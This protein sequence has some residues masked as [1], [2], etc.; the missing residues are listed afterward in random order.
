MSTNNET[1]FENDLSDPSVSQLQGPI[2]K[3]LYAM[4]AKGVKIC[5]DLQLAPGGEIFLQDGTAGKSLV[6][7]LDLEYRF[8]EPSGAFI[9]ASLV[10]QGGD[11]YIDGD[12]N[13][14]PGAYHAGNGVV[15][16]RKAWL[17]ISRPDGSL[18]YKEADG[19]N[20]LESHIDNDGII[21]SLA[22]VVQQINQLSDMIDVALAAEEAAR[23]QDVDELEGALGEWIIDL[24]V[25]LDRMELAVRLHADM[26]DD[27]IATTMETNIAAEAFNVQAES[28]LDNFHHVLNYSTVANAVMNQLDGFELAH[29]LNQLSAY[30]VSGDLSGNTASRGDISNW[31]IRTVIKRTGSQGV[32]IRGEEVWNNAKIV[33][34]EPNGVSQLQVHIQVADCGAMTSSD[35]IIVS[36][37]FVGDRGFTLPHTD[38]YSSYRGHTYNE[39]G[40]SLVYG[41]EQYPWADSDSGAPVYKATLSPFNQ[42]PQ[43]VQVDFAGAPF[44]GATIDV[45]DGYLTEDWLPREYEITGFINGAPSGTVE[46]FLL[47]DYGD[48]W[49]G[50]TIQIFINGSLLQI[51]G[52]SSHALTGKAAMLNL[53]TLNVGDRIQARVDYSGATS[54][55]FTYEMSFS[56][57]EQ[58]QFS[59]GC[60]DPAASNYNSMANVDD[61][62]C[63][64]SSGSGSG[65]SGESGGGSSGGSSSGSQIY[66]CT[67]PSASNY[68]YNATMED[69]SCIYPQTGCMD[70]TAMNYDVNA[71]VS[72]NSC[73]YGFEQ[74]SHGDLLYS[75]ITS[76][77]TEVPAGS[78]PMLYA[79][80]V[81]VTLP[82]A[83]AIEVHGLGGSGTGDVTHVH[84]Q[85]WEDGHDSQWW[86]TTEGEL[87]NM[88]ISDIDS[89]GNRTLTFDFVSPGMVVPYPSVNGTAS[90]PLTG[91]TGRL[92][93]FTTY[94]PSVG[95]MDPGYD[96]YDS[97]H[98]FKAK[99]TNYA[100]IQCNNGSVPASY[101]GDDYTAGVAGLT[102][103]FDSGQDRSTA[104]D[105]MEVS[106]GTLYI[107]VETDN[108]TY[109]SFNLGAGDYNL[110]G[111][112]KLE[113]PNQNL[114]WESTDGVSA[115]L[116][117]RMI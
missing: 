13:S 31:I 69:G 48:G 9:D 71:D 34:D 25:T 106:G 51:N 117:V 83:Q 97:Q 104:V 96:T 68:D 59:L 47:D 3:F 62:S 6:K 99:H 32:E 2:K 82:S 4:E 88:T 24:R 14:V 90:N 56:L 26:L 37:T 17:K 23:Q 64:I 80:Q 74:P 45:V 61:G 101:S 76:T 65:S 84:F 18:T 108:G 33:N 10:S 7:D 79:T 16:E 116:T 63:I 111:G 72:D 39:D 55:G 98:Q 29:D 50:I 110:Q 100:S 28:V 57:G 35:E 12:G 73:I 15:L 107:E 30:G 44:Y 67:D 42:P 21:E 46:M 22:E 27:D 8:Q 43:I 77:I 114:W 66:G 1:P 109:T 75:A 95:C 81:V 36:G 11:D 112:N 19:I 20:R 113:I 94:E 5:G 86:T 105:H 115:T 70:P 93:L 54:Y 92:G 58:G 52:V 60:T 103:K 53:G 40:T 78:M 49:D 41:I 102:I 89:E 38:R 87:N 91:Q 85:N